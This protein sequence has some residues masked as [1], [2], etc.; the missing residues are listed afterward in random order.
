MRHGKPLTMRP[1]VTS[2]TSTSGLRSIS[3]GVLLLVLFLAAYGLFMPSID[4]SMSAGD[5]AQSMAVLRG[6]SNGDDGLAA[7]K[8]NTLVPIEAAGEPAAVA[9]E[10]DVLASPA[11]PASRVPVFDQGEGE[12]EYPGRQEA[13]ER[14]FDYSDP[15]ALAHTRRRIQELHASYPPNKPKAAVFVLAYPIHCGTACESPNARRQHKIK[16][17]TQ[18][19]SIVNLV[20]SLQANLFSKHPYP[21][22]IFEPDWLPEDKEAVQNVTAQPVYWQRVTMDENTLPSYY[23]NQQAIITYLK[24]QH[25]N[26]DL[27]VPNPLFHGFGYF[28]DL[29]RRRVFF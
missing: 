22:V 9:V 25:P 28:G 2:R 15:A 6:T 12:A 17:C 23:E 3:S 4:G 26:G 18:R 8:A 11:T 10:P 19:T 1:S 5:G 24:T 29:H 20:K 21:V 16:D 7:V 13:L 14:M 27:S